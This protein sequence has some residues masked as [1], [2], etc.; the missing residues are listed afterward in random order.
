MNDIWMGPDQEHFHREIYQS[1]FGNYLIT[2]D[3]FKILSLDFIGKKT[4][5]TN[6]AKLT[7]RVI[8]QLNGYFEGKRKF[9]NLPMAMNSLSLF[10]QRVLNEINNIPYGETRS[11]KDIADALGTRSF[12]AIGTA[13]GKNPFPLII[14]C[15]RVIKDDGEL[16]NYT[17]KP[18]IKKYLLDF[19][20]KNSKTYD[21]KDDQKDIYR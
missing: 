11:Y 4:V 1:P 21:R 7:S 12:Q 8:T 9:F 10:Q 6:G 5:R 19:E 18:E 20:R 13:C 16:G 3:D 17:P 14:P 15:H 2:T